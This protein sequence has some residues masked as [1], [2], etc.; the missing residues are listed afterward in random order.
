MSD[1]RRLEAV[2]RQDLASF[3]RKA[4]PEVSAGETFL[5]NWHVQAI[6]V[7]DTYSNSRDLLDLEVACGCQT[8][9]GREGD[10]HPLC[11]GFCRHIT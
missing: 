1:R 4:F 2:L 6:A 9:S 10:R 3:I 5:P 11:P 8:C 7:A